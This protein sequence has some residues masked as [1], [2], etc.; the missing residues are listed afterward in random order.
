MLKP[1]YDGAVRLGKNKK[2]KFRPAKTHAFSLKRRVGD[3][4]LKLKLKKH[5]TKKSSPRKTE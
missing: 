5:Q 1:L 4:F 3:F 2:Y